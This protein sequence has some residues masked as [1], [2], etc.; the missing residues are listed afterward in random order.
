MI[1]LKNY[2]ESMRELNRLPYELKNAAVDGM[3]AAL[4]EWMME[5]KKVAPIDTG[6]LKNKIETEINRAQ[7]EGALISNSY[8][9]TNFNYA[10]YQHEVGSKKGY[11]PKKPGKSLEWLKVTNDPDRSLETVERTIIQ[12]MRGKGW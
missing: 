7:M 3:H 11:R 5:A 2:G 10:Y 12:K 9:S 4:Q 1:E 6:N 8:S